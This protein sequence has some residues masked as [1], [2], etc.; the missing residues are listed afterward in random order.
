[1]TAVELATCVMPAGPDSLAPVEGFIV[2]RAAFYG[3]GFGLSSHQFLRSLLRSYG[4]ELHHLTPSGI[5]HMAAFVTLCEANIRIEL[6][7]N[8]WSHFFWAWLWHDSGAGVASLRT[9]DISVHF[10]P[11]IDSYLS[12]PQPDPPVRWRKAWFLLKDEAYAPLPVF[13]GGCPVPHPD[14][15]HGVAQADFPRL[16]PLLEIVRGLLQMGLTSEEIL[17]TFLSRGVQPL[18]Q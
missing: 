14:C 11:G 4:L 17:R 13:M 15:E 12:I 16:Q 5:L 2:V 3:W 8:L 9:V 18:H 1:M 10:S 7:L 6:P